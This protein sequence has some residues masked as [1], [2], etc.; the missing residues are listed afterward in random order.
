M[1]IGIIGAGHI[2]SRLASLWLQAGHE[3]MLAARDPAC[4]QQL[5]ARLGPWA[6]AGTPLDVAGLATAVL[7]AVPYGA[8]PVLAQELGDALAGKT[9]LDAGTAVS[10]QPQ[11]AA[12]LRSL[13]QH[14]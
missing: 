14:P 8:M 5:A 4:V 7:L 13:L 11:T 12:L 10:D 2:G 1:Q 9:V 3:V 6:L